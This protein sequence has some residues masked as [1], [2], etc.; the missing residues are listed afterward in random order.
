L[1]RCDSGSAF[2]AVS[3]AGKT[4]LCLDGTLTENNQG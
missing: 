2:Q 1:L 4:R 3:G